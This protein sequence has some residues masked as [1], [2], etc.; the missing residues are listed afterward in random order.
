MS[1]LIRKISRAK[2]RGCDEDVSS[3]LTA[4]AITNC[5][6]TTGNTLSVWFAEN[7]E[8]LMPAKVALLASMQKMDTIDI[9]VLKMQDVV[10]KNLEVEVTSGETDAIALRPLHR[11]IAKLT[12]DTLASFGKLVREVIVG[13][14]QCM[15]IT[16]PQF[17][18]ILKYGIE[19]KLLN[20]SD[21][22]EGLSKDL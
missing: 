6:K 21:L 9:V 15:R 12:L 13:Q 16:K 18:E 8:A 5:L 1:Y 3:P 20:P 17:K 2:W 4:D 11:D 7:D 22:K 10:D 14:E 19:N